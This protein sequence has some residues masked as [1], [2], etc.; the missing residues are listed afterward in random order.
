M[1]QPRGRAAARTGWSGSR[2]VLARSKTRAYA[3]EN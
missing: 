3:N 1:T 2:G